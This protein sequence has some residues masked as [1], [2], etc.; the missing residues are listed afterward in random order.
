MKNIKYFSLKKLF[1]QEKE[2]KESINSL[3]GGEKKRLNYVRCISKDAQIYFIDE[4]TN[5]LDDE[6]VKKVVS[7][8]DKLKDEAIVVVVS[9]DSRVI[10]RADNLLTL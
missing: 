10:S 8:L 6:N 4:P 7:M 2:R 5:D 9:H 3:S 1:K